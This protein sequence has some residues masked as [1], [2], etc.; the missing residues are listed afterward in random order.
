MAHIHQG[1]PLQNGPPVIIL[2]TGTGMKLADC[3]PS[4]RD[5][6]GEI[7]NNPSRYYVS[8]DTTEFPDGAL[9]GQL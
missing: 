7:L 4:T 1:E 2:F 9:R 3:A 6:L 8:I 5:Q